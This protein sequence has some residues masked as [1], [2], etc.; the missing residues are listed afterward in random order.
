MYISS[1]S[2]LDVAWAKV[3]HWQRVRHP[4]DSAASVAKNIL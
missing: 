3:V 1:K 4:L 2:W